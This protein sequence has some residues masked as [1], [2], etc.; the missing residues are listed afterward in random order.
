[1][2][3]RRRL[4]FVAKILLAS[5]GCFIG[6]LILLGRI[7]DHYL[8]FRQTDQE[9]RRFFIVN[10]LTGKVGYYKV[11]NRSIRFVSIGA[12]TLPTLFFIHGS[13][14]SVSIYEP[15]FTDSALRDR[16]KMVAVDRPGYGG[17][18][19]GSPEPSIEK[20]VRL[21][22]P[23]IRSL[24]NHQQPLIIVA[25]SYGTSV[26]CRLLMDHPSTADALLL[27]GPSL[28]AGEEKTF[29][30]ADIMESPLVRWASPRLFR[31]ANTEKLAHGQQLDSMLPLW[32]SI[33]VPVFYLQ[34]EKDGL[35]Y[36]A[37]A[38][39]ARKHLTAVPYL[40]IQFLPG[41]PHFFIRT[42]HD[43]IVHTILSAL[44]YLNSSQQLP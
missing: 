30:F 16:F 25:G 12:D 7:V 36:P 28:A 13:P 37:N 41:R 43:V 34:G 19:F 9:I 24:R 44:H 29:W 31:S 21:I 8:Q 26:A 42:D 17:S 27:M 1:V 11:A 32:P 33:H 38:A 18:G 4:L 20:Q 22:W 23:L 2:I 6:A 15:F 5:L 14:S 3:N 39:F 35:I 40:S 10:H